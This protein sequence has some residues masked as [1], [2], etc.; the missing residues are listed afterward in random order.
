MESLAIAAVWLWSFQAGAPAD[1]AP[2]VADGV[3]YYACPDKRLYA[4]ALDSGKRSWAK[5]FKA[6]LDKTP[7]VDDGRLYQ[8][9]P[10]PS[11]EI[12]CWDLA[13]GKRLWRV[14]AGPGPIRPAAGNSLVAVG[15]RHNV[16]IYDNQ[17]GE[18]GRVRLADNVAG[19]A[20][21][22]NGFLAWTTAGDAA[23]IAANSHGEP[24]WTKAVAPG[25]LYAVVRDGCAWFAAG[26]GDLA[27]WEVASG[28][29]LWR[30]SLGE[31]LIA[32]PETNGDLVVTGRR[33]VF[34]ISAAD[35]VVRWRFAPGGNIVGAAPYRGGAVVAAEG[36][37]VYYTCG[38]DGCEIAKLQKYTAAGPM[39]VG[40]YLIVGDGV[41]RLQVYKLEGPAVDA[42]R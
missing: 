23:Y 27:C 12:Q 17:G 41:K 24:V 33:T 42:G 8:S 25:G 14:R 29:E 37:G 30:T 26:N 10:F 6:P 39:V 4:L 40:D 11:E 15:N 1:A 36:G 19:I 28:R 3:I 16:V 13:T 2:T 7:V 35:G 31:A 38:E 22:E 32:A 21:A 20:A 5:S 18:V 9:I 34:G